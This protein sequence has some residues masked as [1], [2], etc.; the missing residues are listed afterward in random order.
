MSY[1]ADNV[2]GWVEKQGKMC[3]RNKSM[4]PNHSSPKWL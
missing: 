4:V 1:F 2:G 3:L